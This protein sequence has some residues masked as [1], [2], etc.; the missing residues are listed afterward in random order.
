MLSLR[1]IIF[2]GISGICLWGLFSLLDNLRE[3][4]L[5]RTPQGIAVKGC[6]AL[7]AHKDAPR[8]CPGFLCQKALVDRKLARVEDRLEITGT[9]GSSTER[10]VAG[11]FL[12]DGRRFTCIVAGAIVTKADVTRA[13][14]DDRGDADQAARPDFTQQ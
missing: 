11:R 10:T 3:P 1:M 14:L 2:A 8:L 5:L 6:E 4:G 7:D 12:D 9:T 13:P